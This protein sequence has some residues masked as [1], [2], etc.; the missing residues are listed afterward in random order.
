[1][2]TA[3]KAEPAPTSIATMTTAASAKRFKSTPSC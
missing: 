2:L 1:L 3:A